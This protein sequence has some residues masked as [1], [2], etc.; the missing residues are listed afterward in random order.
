MKKFNNITKYVLLAVMVLSMTLVQSCKEDIDM[1]A[2]YTFTEYTVESYLAQHDTTYSEYYKLLGEVKISNR[3]E[4]TVLQL[5]S[6]RGNF[7]V[8]APNNEAIAEYLDTLCRK[9][10]ISE[11]SWDGFNGNQQLLDSIRKVIVFNSVID[12]G[13]NNEAY[14]TSS[15]PKDGTEFL[16]ANMNDRKLTITYNDVDPDSM[17]INASKDAKTKVIQGG[18]L[19][20][21]KNRDIVA[22]NGR[23]HQVHS[24]VAPSNQTVADA[25]K[26]FVDLKDEKFCVFANLVLQCGLQDTLSKVKDEVY[27]QMVLNGDFEDKNLTATPGNV[28]SVPDHRKYGFTIFAETN[29]F[30]ES[31]I[32]KPFA[33]ITVQDVKEW[34]IEQ[35]FYPDAK[36]DNNFKDPENVLNLFVTYHIL[37]MNLPVD[38]LV[39]HYNEKGYYYTMATAN[40]KIPVWEIYTTM[41]KPRL[42]KIYQP[43]SDATA[44]GI[45]LNRFPELDNGRQGTYKETA[46]EYGKEGFRVNTTE[47]KNLFNGYIYAIESDCP[48]KPVL[49]YDLETRQ[50]FQKQ[51]LRFDVAGIFPEFINNDIRAN[52]VKTAYTLLPCSSQYPYLENLEI[53]D[54]TTFGYLPGLGK[55]WNN[56]QGDEFNVIGRYEM[57]FTLPPVPVKGTYEIRYAVQNNSQNRSMCQVYFGSNK[58]HMPAIG[59]PLDLRIGGESDIVGWEEDLKDDDDYNAETDKK[60]RNK[61]FMKGAEAYHAGGQGAKTGRATQTT[62]RRIIVRQE[63]DPNKTYYLKFKSVLD[64]TEK[65]FYMDYIEYCAK[66]VYD[67]PNKPEDIW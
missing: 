60:M 12:G 26:D 11:P 36:T 58:D 37:P 4:S 21:L 23:I 65:E 35:G 66:E 1:S 41:G 38:K 44:K 28:S 42:L 57:I 62:T 16:I 59:I 27:E 8:F 9:G 56:W 63:M 50:N 29:D 15:F 61:G 22:I 31:A 14:E 18:S 49:T 24:V 54:G 6:A 39:I 25:L 2:R 3:S 19:I 5:L 10:V 20:D 32:G 67:N 17:Y 46:C 55:G 48:E 51:R 53:L 40:Y 45:Y 52:R 43:N 47:F 13:N 33:E 64:L 30:W 34:V 7:T